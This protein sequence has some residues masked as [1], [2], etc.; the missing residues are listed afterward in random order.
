MEAVALAARSL[1][2]DTARAMSQENVDAMRRAY[3]LVWRE[4]NPEAA[5]E[6]AHPDLEWIG[7]EGDVLRGRDEVIRRF[8]HWDEAWEEFQIDYEFVD[9]GEDQVVA[10]VTMRGRGRGSGAEIDWR[11]GQVWESTNGQAVRMRMYPTH[12]A[13]LEAAG[14]SE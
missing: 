5:F 14:L 4:R 8:A 7:V 11:V 10:L 12:Q 9:A 3:D 2:R 13:A 1:E 6:G